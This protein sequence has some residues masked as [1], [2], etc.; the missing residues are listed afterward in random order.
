[1]SDRISRFEARLADIDGAL[2]EIHRRVDALEARQAHPA[3]T[4][5][6]T[7]PPVQEPAAPATRTFELSSIVAL[8]GRTFV[9]LGGAFLLRAL[10]DS[11][12][13]PGPSGIVLGLAYAVAWFGVADRDGVTRPLSGLFHGLTAMIISLPLVWE[14]S[15]HFRVLSPSVSAVTLVAL[16]GVALVVAWHRRLQSLAGAAV[17]GF[18]IV[19]LALMVATT[20]PLPFG[21]GLL[22]LAAST[23]WLSDA[24]GWGWLRWPPAFAADALAVVLLA[25]ADVIPPSLPRSAIIA[26][27]LVLFAAYVVPVSWHVLVRNRRLHVSEMIQTACAAGLGL[28]GALVAAGAEP[29]LARPIVSALSVA[30]AVAAYAAAFGILRARAGGRPNVVFFA[31]MGLV[32]LVVGGAVLVHGDARII[33]SGALALAAAAIGARTAEPQLSLHATILCVV[34]AIVSGAVAWAANAW[35]ATGPWHAPGIAYGLTGV[36]VTACMIAPAWLSPRPVTGSRL[37]TASRAVEGALV[38]VG[39]GAVAIWLIAPLAAGIPVDRG[40][41]ATFRTGVLAVCG[42][43]AAALSRLTFATPFAWL[44]YPVLAA[45]GV[46]LLTDDFRHSAAA[47]LFA[48]LAVYGATLIVA[49]RL[50]RRSV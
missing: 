32:L 24:R 36:V 13:L 9:V 21:A 44:V 25:R 31:S 14:A 30:A 40:A 50:A 26:L 46:K 33:W 15:T 49:P 4:A 12:R 19:A 5:A 3:T 10:T 39:A 28:L 11:G 38:L 47:T 42:L 41:L 1:M 29:T 18:I 48:A 23:S 43:A 37:A 45:G 2:A 34:M 35:F 16:T 17:I 27:L 20:R 8:L 6:E 7:A 22:A